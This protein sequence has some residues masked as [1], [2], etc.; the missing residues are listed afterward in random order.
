MKSLW[1]SL[2]FLAA[3]QLK[4]K[5]ERS[6]EVRTYTTSSGPVVCDVYKPPNSKGKIVTINGFAPLGSRDPR[7]ISV[8]EALAYAGFTVVSPTIPDICE[9]KIDA[10][11]VKLFDT[12]LCDIASDTSI[13]GHNSVSVLAPSFSG[14]LCLLSAF[15]NPS[16]AHLKAVCMIGSYADAEATLGAVFLDPDVDEY[17]RL[18][19][20]KN[21]IHWSLGRLPGMQKALTTLLHD[22]YFRPSVPAYPAHAQSLVPSTRRT[23]DRLR[24]QEAFRA[25]HWKKILNGAARARTTLARLCLLKNVR[26]VQTAVTLIHGQKDNVVPAEQSRLLHTTLLRHGIKSSLVVTPLISHGDS[27]ITI[28][29]APALLQLCRGFAHFFRFAEMST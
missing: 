3:S 16:P 17:G 12:L 25:L 28:G 14:S 4:L 29:Q 10:G 21:F 24:T 23:L 2:R 1:M 18:I 7:I 8:N 9:Y 20:L 15:Q 11:H 13:G 6:L 19:L 22:N 26:P 27:K 5:A